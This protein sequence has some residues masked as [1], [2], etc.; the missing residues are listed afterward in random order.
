VLIGP[1]AAPRPKVEY[2]VDVPGEFDFQKAQRGALRN[3]PTSPGFRL[4]SSLEIDHV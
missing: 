3:N 4:Q 2:N 1:E